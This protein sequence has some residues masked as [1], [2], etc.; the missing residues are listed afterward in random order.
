MCIVYYCQHAREFQFSQF[1][2]FHSMLRTEIVHTQRF[3]F[4]VNSKR[5][6][7]VCLRNVEH[8]YNRWFSLQNRHKNGTVGRGMWDES[9]L[10]RSRL[11][12]LHCVA[13]I[14]GCNRIERVNARC[15]KLIK[16]AITLIYSIAKSLFLSPFFATTYRIFCVTR[17]ISP[18]FNKIIPIFS[19]A[20][21]IAQLVSLY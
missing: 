18:M 19:C 12:L 14:R 4:L 10:F 20:I 7:R 15:E 9:F 16:F 2:I 5:W 11:W 6:N 17:K 21:E 8:W 13:I 3:W 1:T